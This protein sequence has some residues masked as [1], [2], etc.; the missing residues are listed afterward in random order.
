MYLFLME[1]LSI[2]GSTKTI[3]PYDMP[4]S[5]IESSLSLREYTFHF[6][7]INEIK[8]K[9]YDKESFDQSTSSN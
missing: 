8:P 7:N 6:E 9:F 1:F 3:S 4:A 2:I 5:I